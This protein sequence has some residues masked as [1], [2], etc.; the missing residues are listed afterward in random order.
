M[1]DDKRSGA[2]SGHTTAL[3]VVIVVLVVALVIVLSL[4]LRTCSADKQ[5]APAPQI[6]QTQGSYVKPE[7][8]IDRSKNVTLPGWGGFTIP[9]NE[10]HITQGF[11][12]HNPVENI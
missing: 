6:E 11:E 3:R 8:P 10:Q 1:G 9:A 2:K 7:T 12:F 5:E 4:L